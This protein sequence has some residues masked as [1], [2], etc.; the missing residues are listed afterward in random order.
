MPN[1]EEG[2]LMSRS[3]SASDLSNNASTRWYRT[4]QKET[5]K[6]NMNLDGIVAM[7]V[8]ALLVLQLDDRRKKAI[9]I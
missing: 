7:S 2:D 6:I 8:Y 5:K 3:S 9:D 1:M 4:P